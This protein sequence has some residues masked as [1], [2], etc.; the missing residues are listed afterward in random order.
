MVVIIS[1]VLSILIVALSPGP[2]VVALLC[3]CDCLT[4]GLILASF[5]AVASGVIDLLMCLKELHMTIYLP[6]PVL[7]QLYHL[8]HDLDLPVT[9]FLA[10]NQGP[11][12]AM[13]H[14]PLLDTVCLT[15]KFLIILIQFLQDF[16]KG[17]ISIMCSFL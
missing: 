13:Q 5:A 8:T 14:S 11:L 17:K 1:H 15:F 7:H 2:L 12:N 9:Q 10:P 6:G 4:L 16:C 3:L